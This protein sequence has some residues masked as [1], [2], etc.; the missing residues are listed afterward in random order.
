M[1]VGVVRRRDFIRCIRKIQITENPL[2]RNLPADIGSRLHAV[3][4]KIDRCQHSDGV[5]AP[6]QDHKDQI[7]GP[8][9]PL[10]ASP[11]IGIGDFRRAP[12]NRL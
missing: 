10:A 5:R 6:D 12:V 8:V 1:L 2:C 4:D 9:G 3:A 11:H 7:S